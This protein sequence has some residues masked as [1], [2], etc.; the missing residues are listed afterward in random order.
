RFIFQSGRELI[1]ELERL[2]DEGVLVESDPANAKAEK[3]STGDEAAAKLAANDTEAVTFAPGT[4]P[5]ATILGVP[6][7][8]DADEVVAL[9]LRHLLRRKGYTVDVCPVTT[10]VQD[11]LAT[12]TDQPVDL[13]FVSALPPSAVVAA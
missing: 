9:M 8:D 11:H 7:R 5:T 6:A 10:A 12:Q 1:E 4:V 2:E 13:V 3:S